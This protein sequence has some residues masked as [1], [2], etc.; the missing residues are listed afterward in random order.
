MAGPV[1]AT[2]L[3]GY[4]H[5]VNYKGITF[6]IQTE[7]SGINNPHIITLLYVGGNIVARKKISYADI[8]K[9]ERLQ[10]VVRELMQDQH[11][12]ML[13]DL[14]NH[15]FD[16]HPLVQQEFAKRGISVPAQAPAPAVSKP[17]PA[18]TPPKSMAEAEI[19][20]KPAQK[21]IELSE[22]KELKDEDIFGADIISNKSL[23]EVILGFLSERLKE[24][25]K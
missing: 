2:M 21:T 4:N 9:H 24:D 11:K 1:K 20:E 15:M 7:D 8:I 5:N 22:D 17:A 14:K 18:P 23:D 19:K 3:P 10:D 12:Q 6:H 25:E 16:N 13:K